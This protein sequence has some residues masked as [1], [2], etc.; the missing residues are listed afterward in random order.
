MNPKDVSVLVIDDESMIVDQL[1]YYLSDLGYNVHGYTNPEKALEKIHTRCYDVILTDLKMPA[2]SGMDIVKAIKEKGED[3]KVIIF[4]GFA[5]ADSAISAIKH[6]VYSYIQK[7]YSLNEIRD[8]VTNAATQ[9]FLQ[10]EN[11]ALNKK[12]QNMFNF[13]N[14]LYD[15][16]SILYQVSDFDMA[17]EMILDTINEGMKISKAGIYLWSKTEGQYCIFKSVGLSDV[18]Q[19]YFKFKDGS[20]ING[21]LVTA[22]KAVKITDLGNSI[23]LDD[24]E[25]PNNDNL[26]EIIL[27]P[28]RFKEKRIGHIGVFNLETDLFSVDDYLRLLEIMATQIA[29][30]FYLHDKAEGTDDARTNNQIMENILSEKISYAERIHLNVSFAMINLV[31]LVPGTSLDS[32]DGVKKVFQEVIQRRFLDGGDIIWH[33]FNS[34]VVVRPGEDQVSLDLECSQIKADIEKHYTDTEGKISISLEYGIAVYPFDG[35]TA[36][37]I[38]EKLTLHLLTQN[39]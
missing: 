8:T 11:I 14:T 18:F 24:R 30:V 10:R 1:K 4:T 32:M 20:F 38:L 25:F 2:V 3:T 19:E 9:L 13:M 6:G 23:K 39:E 37:E 29:P 17:V 35:K 15:I 5:T 12:V 34:V 7:P 27:C 22:D 33:N 16:A 31:K 36:G 21:H 28:I 26:T